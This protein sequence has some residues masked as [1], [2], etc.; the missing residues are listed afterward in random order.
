M[1][2]ATAT[3]SSSALCASIGPRDHVAD[4]VDAGHVGREVL[5]DL[6]MRPRSSSL[7]PASSRPSPSRVGHAADRDQHDVGLERL[8]RRRP[9]AGST[10]TLQRCA[11]ALDPGHLG[12]ELEGDALLFAGCAGTAWPPR[13]PCR[14]GCG[15]DIRP[16]S[17]RRRAAARPSRARGRS[18]RR[19]SPPA[20]FGTFASDS[21]PVEETMRFSS[22][23][24][25]RERRDVRAGGDDD[26]LGLERSGLAVVGG[27]LDLAGAERCGRCRGSASILF[28]LNR[29]S[30]PLTLPSTPSSLKLHHRGEIELGLRTSMP[31]RGEA[32]G[33]PPRT[34]RRRAAAPSTGCSR[35]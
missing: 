9:A 5:I 20:C 28:F 22:M 30:T 18:R 34:A 33:P 15:R 27:D 23:V 11:V 7:T 2:S 19:R 8:A 26:R 12:A 1:I 21:A 25:A 35:H 6:T 3:P 32:H 29:K 24:D 31:M 4:G 14:A 10:V 17:P 16:P 13:R